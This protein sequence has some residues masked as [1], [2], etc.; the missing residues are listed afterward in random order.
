VTGHVVGCLCALVGLALA[1]VA[2]VAAFGAV[3]AGVASLLWLVVG[4]LLVDVEALQ[5]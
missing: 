2:A 3:G 1:T 4:V 5:R